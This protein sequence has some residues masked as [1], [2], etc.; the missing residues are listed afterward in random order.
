M[1]LFVRACIH[2]QIQILPPTERLPIVSLRRGAWKASASLNT[3]RG[4]GISLDYPS[5]Q[6]VLRQSRLQDYGTSVIRK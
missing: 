2:A 5:D 4:K 3:L 6:E 1:S